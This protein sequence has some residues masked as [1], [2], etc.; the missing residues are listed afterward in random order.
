MNSLELSVMGSEGK[1]LIYSDKIIRSHDM[2][3]G[4]I[5]RFHFLEMEL[6]APTLFLT[7]VLLNTVFCIYLLPCIKL[8]FNQ[9][10]FQ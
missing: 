10:Q 6:P 4:F 1:G 9:I 2:S 7:L 8:A 3:M 5:N